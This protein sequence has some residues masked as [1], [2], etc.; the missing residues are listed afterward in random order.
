LFLPLLEL[1]HCQNPLVSK[2]HKLLRL[3]YAYRMTSELYLETPY[4]GSSPTNS[5]KRLS[6]PPDLTTILLSAAN[7]MSHLSH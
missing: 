4:R 5:N 1:L 3:V 6:I 7:T 2:L